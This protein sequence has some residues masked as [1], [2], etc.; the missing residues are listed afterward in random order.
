MFKNQLN[1]FISGQTKFKSKTFY[2]TLQG[3]VLPLQ[4]IATIPRGHEQSFS[5]VL[6]SL[7][8]LSEQQ[9]KEEALQLVNSLQQAIQELQ[10]F[11]Y[12]VSHDL[13]APLHAIKTMLKIIFFD[14]SQLFS[15]QTKTD[16]IRI[17]QKIDLMINL[18]SE[19]LKYAEIE[20]TKDKFEPFDLNILIQDII[21][22]IS[23]PEHIKIIVPRK[24]P[25]FKYTRA[26]IYQLFQNLLSNAIKYNDK[27]KG[28]ITL[29]YH[30]KNP[31]SYEFRIIDNGIGIEKKDYKKIFQLFQTVSKTRSPQNTGVGL[32][33]VKKIID[34]IGG[35]IYVESVLGEKTEFIFTIPTIY[36]EE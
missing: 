27:E 13:K 31:E 35:Q 11:S 24:F 15:T 2:R 9:Y 12:V 30:R 25:R 14:D 26:K 5:K 8:D 36:I 20:L 21:E 28:L 29:S 4:L 17:N 22:V 1:A 10:D 33:I 6:V 16:L 18:I 3:N 34:L 7:L 19:I 23:P 32:A